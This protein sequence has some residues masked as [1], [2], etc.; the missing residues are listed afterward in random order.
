MDSETGFRSSKRAIK[1]EVKLYYKI[2]Q[3]NILALFVHFFYLVMLNL[4]TG[5]VENSIFFIGITK[6]SEVSPPSGAYQALRYVSY[7]SI[8]SGE[9]FNSRT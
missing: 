7:K 3:K 6:P 4:N 5:N 2:F 9:P 1:K 8:E